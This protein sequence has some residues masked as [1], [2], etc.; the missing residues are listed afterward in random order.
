[1]FLQDILNSVIWVIKAKK[2]EFT[3][4]DRKLQPNKAI[5]ATGNSPVAF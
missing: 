2:K 5:K 4:I 1:M 3:G